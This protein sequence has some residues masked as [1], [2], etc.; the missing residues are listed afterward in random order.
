MTGCNSYEEVLEKVQNGE[1]FAGI[2]SSD[3]AG[4]L[5]IDIYK[6]DLVIPFLKDISVPVKVLEPPE[7]YHND[8]AYMKCVNMYMQSGIETATRKYRKFVQVFKISQGME[9]ENNGEKK[10]T[11]S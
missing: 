11:L 10:A 5:A 7:L 4:H 8:T 2:M 3:I 9:Y 1:A 6:K